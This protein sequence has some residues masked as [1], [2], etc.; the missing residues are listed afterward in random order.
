MDIN[1]VKKLISKKYRVFNDAIDS[2]YRQKS[3]E[4]L[5]IFIFEEN[6]KIILSDIA[7]IANTVGSELSEE[8]LC[9]YAKKFGLNVNDWHVE[10]EFESIKSVDDFTCFIGFIV[11]LNNE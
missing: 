7:E 5:E 9:A 11:S 2:G 8:K 6:G 3:G 1:A 4:W 10:T